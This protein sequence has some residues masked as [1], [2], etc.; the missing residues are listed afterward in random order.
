[1]NIAELRDKSVEELCVLR[2]DLKKEMAQA[3]LDAHGRGEHAH[4]GPRKKDM[5]RILT[6]LHDKQNH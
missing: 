6:V 4:I 2:D 1:M 5:A 3:V